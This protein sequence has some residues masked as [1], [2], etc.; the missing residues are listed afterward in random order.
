VKKTRKGILI[1]L[2]CVAVF[3][4][5]FGIRV[6]VDH[7]NMPAKAV[8]DEQPVY[9]IEDVE[10]GLPVT[11]AVEPAERLTSKALAATTEQL[12]PVWTSNAAVS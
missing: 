1:L 8:I 9:A 10:P 5:G 2:T 4:L 6:I 11:T 12:K 7:R 3:G